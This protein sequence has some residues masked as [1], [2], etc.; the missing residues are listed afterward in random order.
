MTRRMLVLVLVLGSLPLLAQQKPGIVAEDGELEQRGGARVLYW[1]TMLD[2]PAG[3]LAIEY[4]RPEWKKA[5]EDPAKFDSMTK[6]KVWRMGKNFFTLL[7][8]SLPLTISGHAVP[9]GY[10]FLGLGRSADGA[11]W[12]LSFFDPAKIRAAHLDGFVVNKAHVEFQVPV[13][14]ERSDTI[15]DKLSITLPYEKETPTKISFR[16]AWGNFVATVPIDVSLA[17]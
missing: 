8:T 11:H 5:Y 9:P 13:K 4:G 2:A 17:H 14:V 16:L 7:D 10:Y 6:G 12:S 1:N 15:T 3:Q